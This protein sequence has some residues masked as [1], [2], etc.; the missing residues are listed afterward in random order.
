VVVGSR[1]LNRWCGL[2]G[3]DMVSLLEGDLRGHVGMYHGRGLTVGKGIYQGCI[4][5]LECTQA[6]A[7]I[8]PGLFRGSILVT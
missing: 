5:G 2:D 6:I 8:L 1:Q 7:L 4:I 3:E